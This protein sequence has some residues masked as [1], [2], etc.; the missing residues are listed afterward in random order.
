VEDVTQLVT[1]LIYR[2]KGDTM[3]ENVKEFLLMPIADQLLSEMQDVCSS[4]CRRFMSLDRETLTADKDEVDDY[5][6]RLEPDGVEEPEPVERRFVRI[7]RTN[8]PCN[9]GFPVDEDNCCPLFQLEP[10]VKN[11]GE[12]LAIIKRVAVFR[13]AQA[14]E[15]RQSE[16]GL[17]GE[18]FKS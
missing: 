13:K 14:A 1:D 3:P 7:E 5:W 10:S 16:K 9:V 15:K 12:L 2:G 6:L 17:S 18:R 4:D 11:V 8:E